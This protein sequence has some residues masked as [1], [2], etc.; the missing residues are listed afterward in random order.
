MKTAVI[1]TIQMTRQIRDA[2]AEHLAHKNE[3]EIVRFY[4]EQAKQILD[5]LSL[6]MLD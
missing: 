1:D 6:T 4:E 5:Q 2:H 3:Q